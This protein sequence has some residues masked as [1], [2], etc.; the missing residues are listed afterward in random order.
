[1]IYT[2]SKFLPKVCSKCDKVATCAFCDNTRKGG[3]PCAGGTPEDSRGQLVL[4]YKSPQDAIF[5]KDVLL[6][7]HFVKALR[8]QALSER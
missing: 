7:D 2:S 3:L 1:M 5:A 4:F 6:A 8:T